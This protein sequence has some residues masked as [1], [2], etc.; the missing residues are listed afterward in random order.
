MST[1]TFVVLIILCALVFGLAKWR[2]SEGYTP[3]DAARATAEPIAR[4]R[5]EPIA[6]ARTVAPAIHDSDAVKE[7]EAQYFA[8]HTYAGATVDDY[9][10]HALIVRID[11][12]LWDA[13]GS[14]DRE[15]HKR[16]YYNEWVAAYAANHPKKW[17]HYAPFSVRIVDLTGAQLA[18][19]E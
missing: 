18:V 19:E 1:R 13:W 2:G 3:S 16:G 10:D 5:T 4:A 15:L 17:T 8:D 11:G 14:Q 6:R 7:R 9:N 12:N